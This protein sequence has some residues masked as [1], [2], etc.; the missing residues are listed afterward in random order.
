[1]TRRKKTVLILLSIFPGL[2]LL[3]IAAA[4]AI[5]GCDEPPP[6]D[7]DLKVQRLVIPDDQN[8]Y[9]YFQVAARKLKIPSPDIPVPRRTED[10]K[11]EASAPRNEREL[12]DAIV[13]G[14]SWD[15][16][17]VERVLKDN[18]E[19]LALWEEGL[20]APHCQMAEVKSF[21]DL[22]PHAFDDLHIAN[23]IML[24]ARFAVSRGEQ[25]AALADRMRLAGFGYQLQTGGGCLVEYLVAITIRSMGVVA[26]RDGLAD[27]GTNGR[28]LRELAR[29]L[30][31]MTAETGLADAYRIEYQVESEL[32]EGIESGEYTPASVQ[33]SYFPSDHEPDPRQDVLWA[34]ICAVVFKPQE[35][36][37]DFAEFARSRVAN[38]SK[39]FK[40]MTPDDPKFSEYRWAQEVFSGNPLGRWLCRIS[41][42]GAYAALEQKCRA[43]VDLAATRILLAL[44]AYKLEKGKLPATLAELAP[45]YLD[46]VP[47]DDFDGQPMRS[48]AARR[49]VYSVGKD[50]KDDGGSGTRAEYVA[51]KRRQAEASGE[52]WTDED[53]KDAE[54]QFNQWDQPDACYEI[55]F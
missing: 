38:V 43:N 7:D 35:T 12:Y 37:R 3:L 20:G 34:A 45:E 21:Y 31:K 25:E 27:S 49:V 13:G 42:R 51:A 4:L 39:P 18:A 53:Q 36:R 17:F 10:D 26:V 33:R 16:L 22:F 28:R 55:R 29:Q 52:K 5:R 19:A 32:V 1:M 41:L 8:A 50:L 44:K 30:S 14:T 9:T 2:P 47:L 24:R 54:Q 48:N 46:S 23:L 40:N 15:S 11:S 6:E